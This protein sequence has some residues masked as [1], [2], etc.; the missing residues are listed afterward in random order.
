MTMLAA[1]DSVA[2]MKGPSLLKSLIGSMWAYWLLLLGFSLG[3]ATVIYYVWL[4][5]NI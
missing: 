2:T 5:G 3:L 4:R 1:T